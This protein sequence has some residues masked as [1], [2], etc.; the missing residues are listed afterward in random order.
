[1][2]TTHD[3]AFGPTAIATPAGTAP[4][5]AA[6]SNGPAMEVVPRVVT[7]T[8]AKPLEEKSIDAKA[9]PNLS[10]PPT[11]AAVPPRAPVMTASLTPDLTAP[12]PATEKESPKMA[13]RRLLLRAKALIRTPRQWCKGHL[14]GGGNAECRPASIDMHAWTDA[15]HRTQTGAHFIADDDCTQR[16]AHGVSAAELERR[17]LELGFVEGASVEVLHEGPVGRDPIARRVAQKLGV[18]LSRV[19]GTGP[20]GRISKEDVEAFASAQ[21]SAVAEPE[22]AS[23]SVRERLTPMRQTIARRLL[24][25]KQ[26][27]PHYRL[28][29]TVEVSALLADRA[30]F[31]ML[32]EVVIM[33]G[34]IQPPGNITP[35]AEFKGPPPE[36]LAKYDANNTA[37]LKRLV[38]AGTQLKPFPQEVMQACFKAANELYEDESAKNPKFKKIYDEWKKFRASEAEWFALTES[39]MDQFLSTSL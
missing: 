4:A 7:S 6:S 18:D 5:A 13:A 1:M 20:N 2:T 16:L 35:L 21:T 14:S 10:E 12:P 34:A 28:E 26:G 29:R 24:E 9:N 11:I 25:S 39:A 36:V 38:Q 23:G 30:A 32:K 31:A 3:K 27:I 15:E 37:A 17:L 19:K 22:A 33:G 8:S